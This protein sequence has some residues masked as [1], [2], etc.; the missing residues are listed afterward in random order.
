V[1]TAEDCRVRNSYQILFG[2]AA[3]TD[4]KVLQCG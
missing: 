4:V 1:P 2:Q 3:Q